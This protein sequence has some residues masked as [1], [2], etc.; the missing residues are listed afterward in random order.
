[1]YPQGSADAGGADQARHELR[2]LFPKLREFVRHDHQMGQ[3]LL[4]LSLPV[5]PLVL[6]DM[7]HLVFLTGIEYPLAALHLSL[8]GN[9]GPAYAG[10]DI[11]D[12]P[13]HIGQLRQQVCHA[14]ALVVDQHEHNVMGMIVHRHGQD[15]GLQGLALSGA[16]GACHQPV[17]AVGPLVDVQGERLASPQGADGGGKTLVGQVSRPSLISLQLLHPL[18][19]KALQEADA[20]RKLRGCRKALQ[21]YGGHGPAI[22][23]EG[24]R[25]HRRGV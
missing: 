7:V 5:Q 11:R 2:L 1:M 21:L 23:V 8:Q 9:Q 10:A 25:R 12:L 19:P 18:H 20:L 6:V 13:H 14:S 3:G 24:F 15:P 16:C 22:A 17:G 4:G